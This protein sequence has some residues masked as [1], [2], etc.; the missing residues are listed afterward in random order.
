MGE[1]GV[2]KGTQHTALWYSKD[3]EAAYSS[4]GQVVAFWTTVPRQK[5][6]RFSHT[7]A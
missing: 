5:T 4:E 3:S 6:G 1:K 2:E 7:M